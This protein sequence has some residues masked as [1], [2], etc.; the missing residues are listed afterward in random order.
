MHVELD[1]HTFGNRAWHLCGDGLQRDS[2]ECE[3]GH[4]H[5]CFVGSRVRGF[6]VVSGVAVDA[7]QGKA[8]RK[9]HM[10]AWW[11]CQCRSKRP[12]ILVRIEPVRM[13]PKRFEDHCAL[14]RPG[15]ERGLIRRVQRN[16]MVVQ[17]PRYD[18]LRT[19]PK[20][21]HPSTVA[22][23][24]HEPVRHALSHFAPV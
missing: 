5:S 24:T 13:P 17:E 8:F 15:G 20:L 2:P 19:T 14:D 21:A 7:W 22:G 18:W 3:R 1:A 4:V 23:T 6:C 16:A 12:A 10:C 11:N 9:P